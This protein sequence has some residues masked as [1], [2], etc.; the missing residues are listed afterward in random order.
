MNVFNGI[1][2][3]NKKPMWSNVIKLNKQKGVEEYELR[4]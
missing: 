2:K 4:S 3:Y 1:R